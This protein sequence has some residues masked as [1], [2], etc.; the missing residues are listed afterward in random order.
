[1]KPDAIVVLSGGIVPVSGGR[2]RATTYAESDAFGTLG[3]HDRARAAAYLAEEYKD[4][5]VVT[6]SHRLDNALPTLARVYAD[7]LESLG[8]PK[9]RI[10]L[11]ERSTTT[12]TAIQTIP[13]LARERGWRHVAVVSSGFHIPRIKAFF[14]RLATDVTADFLRSEEVIVRHE[15]AFVKELEQVKA[16]PAYQ[17]RLQNEANG[18]V[19]LLTGTYTPAGVEDKK[20]REV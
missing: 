17:L 12:Q 1:M 15:P 3:G 5:I 19:A 13:V 10:L 6:T 18:L 14:E 9:E 20:E 7:E 2:W 8:V 11:E 4:A 16:S